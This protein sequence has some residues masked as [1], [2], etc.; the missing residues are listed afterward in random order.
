M[1]ISENLELPYILSSQAQKHVTHNEAIRRLDAL[2]QLSVESR[3]ENTPPLAPQPGARYLIAPSGT[4]EWQGHDNKIAAWQ[5][6]AWTFLEPQEGWLCWLADVHKLIIHNAGEWIDVNGDVSPLAQRVPLL[7]VNTDADV[8]NRLAIKAEAA[9]FSHDGSDH[10]LKLNKNG[11]GDTGSI[12][13]QSNWTGYAE[14]GLMGED[15][16]SIKHSSDGAN[17]LQSMVLDSNTGKAEFPLNAFPEHFLVNMF[18]DGGRFGSSPESTDKSAGSFATP[19]YFNPYNGSSFQLEGKFTHNNSTFGGTGAA[20]GASVQTLMEY[21]KSGAASKRYGPE[22]YVMKILQGT[23]SGAAVSDQGVTRYLSFTTRSA[24]FWS[25]STW[26]LSLQVTSK[27][28]AIKLYE[29]E[30]MLFVDGVKQTQTVVLTPADGW[31]QVVFVGVRDAS[32]YH[33]YESAAYKIYGEHGAGFS[34]ALPF[35]CPAT[36]IPKPGRP[37]GRVPSFQVWR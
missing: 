16:F 35:L 4:G 19:A 21:L 15:R 14:M 31:K 8:L 25:K 1:E 36:I 3:T 7:G 22:F 23:G 5:D 28:V 6:G 10:R 20:L 11:T 18:H 37:F 32:E 30:F 26:G 27:S 17:W 24:S 2:V 13:F 29:N 34:I 12:L 9:L 33:E